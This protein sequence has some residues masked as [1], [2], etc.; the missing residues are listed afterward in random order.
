MTKPSDARSRA[1][2]LGPG[3]LESIYKKAMRIELESRKLACSARAD[4]SEYRGRQIDGQRVDLIIE[5]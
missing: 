5:G 2:A 1:Q 3:F 4:Q